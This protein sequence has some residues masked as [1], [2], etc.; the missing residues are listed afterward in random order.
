MFIF[1]ALLEWLAQ[2]VI[3]V[4]SATGEWGVFWLMAA[5]SA[6]ILIPSEVIMPFAG[7]LASRG[8][9]GFWLVVLAGALGNLA[10]SLVS[11]WIGL[12]GGRPFLQRYGKYF[13]VSQKELEW[14]DR[15]F[16]KHGNKIA[17]W[18]RLLPVVRTFISLPAGINR[19]P[20]KSFSA[21]T[22]LGS[23]IW[24]WLLAYVGLVLG[25]NWETARPFFERFAWLIV[26]LGVL[27]VVVYVWKHVKEL[28]KER[29]SDSRINEDMQE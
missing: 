23:F 2:L 5:E 16:R 1:H 17:F 11:Y 18:S 19:A 6:N 22:F 24:S 13:F 3:Q 26:G 8:V 28:R 12:K 20:L 27:A 7:F 4:I 29:S 10:G 14:G 9:L 15:A 21:Y 25:E